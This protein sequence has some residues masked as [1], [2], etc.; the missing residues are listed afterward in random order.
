[1]PAELR[2]TIWE[3]VL[4]HVDFLVKPVRPPHHTHLTQHALTHTQLTHR[5]LVKSRDQFTFEQ[6]SNY[7]ALTVTCHQIHSETRLL[8]FSLNSFTVAVKN[9]DLLRLYNYLAPDQAAAIRS[10]RYKKGE[11]GEMERNIIATFEKLRDAI[12]EKRART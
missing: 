5:M 7:I 3:L 12:D 1:L 9:G 10:L 11:H 2:I 8:P 6:P 4:G